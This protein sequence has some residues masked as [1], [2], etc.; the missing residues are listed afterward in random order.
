METPKQEFIILHPNIIK[1]PSDHCRRTE[2]EEALKKMVSS[3]KRHGMVNPL[4]VVK[5]KAEG[6]F[7]L[8]AGA[9][10][11]KAA[12]IAGFDK[13]PCLL[14]DDCPRLISLVENEIRQDLD[15]FDKSNEYQRLI[16]EINVDQKDFAKEI[17]MSEATVSGIL[18]LQK[19]SPKIVDKHRNEMILP[20]RELIKISVKKSFEEQ[21]KA[22]EEALKKKQKKKSN[23]Q[24]KLSVTER[25]NN[26]VASLMQ[27]VEK[28]DLT[29]VNLAELNKL[30]PV[31]YWIVL[32]MIELLKSQKSKPDFSPN[33]SITGVR[34]LVVVL[35]EKCADEKAMRA[36]IG[37]IRD[38]ER[39]VRKICVQKFYAQKFWKRL[40]WWI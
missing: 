26:K 20:E 39:S 29:K 2:N 12:K 6:F 38:I 9:M 32:I 4:T 5:D 8:K 27:G 3:I 22:Y 18:S 16:R 19:L 23:G 35:A 1:I 7:I 34:Q 21:E 31:Y 30:D 11:L 33:E 15:P 13:V 24:T 14:V 37:E 25:I 40:A 36:F 28:M 10:R 17:C